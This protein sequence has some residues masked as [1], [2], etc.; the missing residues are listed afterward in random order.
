MNVLV[1]GGSSGLGAAITKRVAADSNCR[2]YFTYH[3]SID[4]AKRMEALASN[5]FAIRCNFKDAAEVDALKEQITKLD[6]NVLVNNAYIGEVIKSHFHKIPVSDFLIGFTDN[7]IPT[8]MLTQAAISSFRKK[9]GGKII[10][11]LTAGLINTPPL[12]SAVYNANKAYLEQLTKVW[13]V[14]NARYNITSNSVS[15]AS[16]QTA[17]TGDID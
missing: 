8:I 14:E 11:V 6:I 3:K 4:E 9:K 10:T 15:P 2:V 5:I 1:T 16:M 7:I 12:G 13:A 17:L